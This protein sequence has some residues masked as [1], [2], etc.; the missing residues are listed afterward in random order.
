MKEKNTKKW[1]TYKGVTPRSRFACSELWLSGGTTPRNARSRE[2]RRSIHRFAF[3]GPF[4][5]RYALSRICWSPLICS[6]S[7]SL[8]CDQLDAGNQRMGTVTPR[9][10]AHNLIFCVMRLWESPF[11]VCAWAW[12]CSSLCARTHTFSFFFFYWP[13]STWPSCWPNKKE[14]KE[15]VRTTS[16]FTTHRLIVFRS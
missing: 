3:S 7:F 1:G 14:I 15:N 4:F 9:L 2:S 11:S 12:K 5:G 6:L 13:T 8:Y 16:W 10:R